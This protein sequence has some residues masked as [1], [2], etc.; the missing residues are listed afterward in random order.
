VGKAQTGQNESIFGFA[1]LLSSRSIR[2]LPP[3]SALLVP[4]S[5][6]YVHPPRSNLT[7]A[8]RIFPDA[9][10]R[11]LA[12]YDINHLFTLK[13]EMIHCSSPSE[14]SNIVQE[15]LV[16]ASEYAAQTEM[17]GK[18]GSLR[19]LQDTS[20]AQLSSFGMTSYKASHFDELR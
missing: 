4:S 19:Y 14:T 12:W 17:L 5:R 18:D 13:F 2:A 10:H 9:T 11:S 8:Q 3:A 1:S 20:A 15:C 16:L 6:M 7:K